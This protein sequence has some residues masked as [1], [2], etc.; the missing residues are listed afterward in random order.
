MTGS[1]A[2]MEKQA[3]QA[4]KR[5]DFPTA[6]EA[7]SKARAAYQ[8]L[9]NTFKAAEMANNLCVIHL[10]LK[11]PELALQAVQG[12]PQI[13]QQH[14][15]QKHEAFAHGNLG[16]AL[17]ACGRLDEAEEAY[18]RAIQMFIELGEDDALEQTSQ[19]LSEM[20]LKQGRSMEA[21]FSMKTGLENKKKRSLKDRILGKLFDSPGNLLK[22]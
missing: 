7:Y 19:S 2:E 21:M 20:L 11:Q 6:L 16:A 5:K 18:K 1:P 8:A 10:Q 12:T 3:V 13:F 9:D 15:D 22:R 14:N 4:Y 17:Q